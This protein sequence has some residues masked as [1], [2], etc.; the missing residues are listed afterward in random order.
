MKL[1]KARADTVKNVLMSTN[2]FNKSNIMSYGMADAD[3]P[4]AIKNPPEADEQCRVVEVAL[5]QGSCQSIAQSGTLG[6]IIK[7]SGVVST[8]VDALQQTITAK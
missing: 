6:S 1:S 4:A 8:A 3:C 7:N 5:L 2:E